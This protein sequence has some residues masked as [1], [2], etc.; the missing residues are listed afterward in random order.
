MQFRFWQ[1]AL[2]FAYSLSYG[3]EDAISTLP[4]KGSYL[5]WGQPAFEDNSFLFDEAINQEKGIMQYVSSLYFDNVNGGNLIFGFTNEIP[6]VGERHQLNYTINYHLDRLTPAN[7]HTNGFGDLSIGYHYKASGKRN[8]IMAI[9]GISLIIPTGNAQEGRGIGGMGARA[10]I[11]FTKRLSHKWV[12]HYTLGYTFIAQA[13]RYSYPMGGQP[14]LAYEKNLQ[15]A[16]VGGGVT[17]Y[18]SRKKVLFAEL[19]SNFITDI[20]GD[21]SLLRRNLATINPGFRFAIDANNIQIV[22][23]I[24][25]P[26]VLAD[27][28]FSRLGIFFYLSIETEYLPFTRQKHR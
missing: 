26:I 17:W 15:Y 22:P 9:P 19:I 20:R 13:D 25:T 18:V 12:T 6:L 10:G 27:G 8:W 3:Q 5:Y 2:I 14:V 16:G 4:K 7:G 1:T 28:A 24:S 21:G 23:G 11:S